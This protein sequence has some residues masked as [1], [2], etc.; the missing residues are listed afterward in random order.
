MT[1]GRKIRTLTRRAEYLRQTIAA[2]DGMDPGDSYDRAE[3]TALEFALET[4][5]EVYGNERSD[6]R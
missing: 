6:H 1:V 3:L 4:I 5:R 2:S